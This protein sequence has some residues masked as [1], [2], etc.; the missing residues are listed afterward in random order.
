MKIINK[1]K[2]TIL[3]EEIIVADTILKRMKGLLG[4]KGLGQGQAMILRPCNQIHTLF[5]NFAIDVLFLDKD[6]R[7]VKAI[8]NL[9]PFRISN[10]YFQAHLAVELPA[11][12]LPASFTSQGDAI[13]L[14]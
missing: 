4:K 8:S 7:V 1:T 9:K 14:E 6:N 10:I 12:T 11:G 3:A 2:N 5:M 13:S